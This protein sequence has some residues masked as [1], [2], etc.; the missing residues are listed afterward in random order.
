MAYRSRST[1]RT[2]AASPRKRIA[3]S[4]AV[5]SM[6]RKKTTDRR[7][8][9][10]RQHTGL[11]AQLHEKGPWVRCAMTHRVLVNREHGLR[12][13]ITTEAASASIER[14]LWAA[15]DGRA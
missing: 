11:Q 2:A 3:R 8:M 4:P 5:Q 9:I 6:I 10:T 13:L 12:R 14:S 7:A 1:A 15:A